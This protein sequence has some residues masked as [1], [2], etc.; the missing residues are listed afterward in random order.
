MKTVAVLYDG[1]E[2]SEKTRKFL[3]EN[4]WFDEDDGF[5]WLTEREILDS[6]NVDE[7]SFPQIPSSWWGDSGFSPDQKKALEKLWDMGQGSIEARWE[8]L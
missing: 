5:F 4:G 1:R 6:L 2:L 3:E 7:V 8:N